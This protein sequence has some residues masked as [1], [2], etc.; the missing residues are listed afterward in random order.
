MSKKII[1]S[2]LLAGVL[3][4]G[5]IFAVQS[6]NT[7]NAASPADVA[8]RMGGPSDFGLGGDIDQLATALDKT[9]DEIQTAEKAAA[10]KA[11]DAA[12]TKGYITESQATAIK[13]F[14][15]VGLGI[16][17]RYITADQIAA[18][19]YQSLVAAE[20]G[21]TKEQLTTAVTTAQ[22]SALQEAV[23]SGRLTQADADAMQAMQQ[24]RAST[25]FRANLR[26]ALQTALGQEVTSGTIT[27]AQ[28][29]ALLERFDSND[30]GFGFGAGG[31]GGRWD[32]PRGGMM[33]GMMGDQQGMMGGGRAGMRGGSTPGGM[34]GQD[35]NAPVATPPSN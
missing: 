19:D 2:L 11:V 10:V 8:A 18:L 32:G 6:Y 29:N 20:L 33:G 35:G 31:P 17:A 34:W 30:T 25:T 14:P 21:I 7:V 23:A 3:A 12:L 26:A 1:V 15:N 24:L 28:Q 4:F 22:Q 27:Q 16:L 5:G 13:A 9:V